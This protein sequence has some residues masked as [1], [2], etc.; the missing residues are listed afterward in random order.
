MTAPAEMVAGS[1]NEGRLR[2]G[3]RHLLLALYTALRSLKL[4]PIENATVQK[5]LDDLG[6]AARAL[7]AL[8]SDLEI[9]MAGDF[10]FVNATRLRLE[11]DNYA[12]FSHVLAVFR[13]FSIGALR[14]HAGADRREWQ[15]LLS[16]LLSLA[17][18]G[19]PDERFEELFERLAAGGVKGIAIERLVNQEHDPDA[20]EA[21]E[22]A[23]RIYSQGVAV[24]KDVITGAR[25][26][27]ATS[28][29]RVKRAVQ[30][31][32]DQVLNNETS[33]VGLTTIRDYDEYTFTH[34]VNV[35][36]FSV[37]LGK[38]LGF[39]RLQLYDLGMTALLHDVGKA[40]VPVEILN[41]TSGLDEQE[42]RVMQGHPWLGALTLFGMRAGD[43]LPYRAILVAHEHHMKTD[44]TGY[45]RTIRE[46]ALG[47]YSRVVSVA[48]GF[49]AATTRRS[50]Q[51]VPIEPDQVLREMWQNPKRG[52]DTILVKALINLIGIYPVGTCVIL[53]TFEVG[54]VAAPNPEGQQLNRPMVRIAVD[55]DG[56]MVPPPG[57]LVSLSEQDEAGAF[58]RSIVKVT[59]PERY[60]LTVGDYFV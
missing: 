54:L 11:L 59:H 2:Q 50:Y 1:A 28:V 36:I 41:K 4:Y 47:I 56:G 53:D 37:A 57:T 55:A 58:R 18:R 13:A 5:A 35:C 45:P 14:V 15:I 19:E 3:G 33:L 6:T 40:R 7:V 31:I 42:W 8:E 44:L 52:Y 39:T 43:E 34:S 10:I 49:D 25:L 20:E 29:K 22:Q 32:V 51:T 12:A 30:L 48:D 60:G 21:K 17:E 26:G 38:K 9:R 23:K 27:R 16:L 46:R 24:T